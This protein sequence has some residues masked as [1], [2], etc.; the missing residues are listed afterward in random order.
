MTTV[1]PILFSSPMVRALLAGTKTQTRRIL[2]PQ[3]DQNS[4]LD[5]TRAD[6]AAQGYFWFTDDPGFPGNQL[7]RSRFATGDLLWVRETWSVSTIYDGVRPGL[8][9]PCGV[10]YAATDAR[11][12]IKDRPSIFMPRWA[13]RLTLAITDVRIERLQSIS[14]ADAIAEGISLSAEFLDRYLTPAGDYATP[15]VAYQRLWDHIN[16]PGA[17]DANPWVVA[18]TFTVHRQNVD[19]FLAQR[20]RAA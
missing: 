4:H 16:G 1:R 5:L 19:E 6:A 14:E 17:W 11:L 15:T 20:R 12:G 8:V 7:I 10:G 3:P 9:P 13:S 2:K 18:L